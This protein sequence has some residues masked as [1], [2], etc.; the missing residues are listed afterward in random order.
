[1]KVDLTLSHIENHMEN[2]RWPLLIAGP[3]SAES[4]A[5][6]LD[7][8]RQLKETKRISF[9]RAGVWK[10]RTRPG[11]FEGMGEE[12]LK[13]LKVVKEETGLH[14][15]CEVATAEHAELALKYGVDLLWVGARTSANPFSVQD[16]ADSIK[17]T[18][19]AVLVKN[20]VNPDLQLW[21]GALER[22]N[23]AGITSLAAIHRGFSAFE[24]SAFR[25]APMW[26]I[27]IELKAMCPDL[28]V[29]CDPSHIAG[30]RELVP[31]VAQ[32]ALDLDVHGLMVEVHNN[33]CIAKS[34]AAQQLLPKDYA[35]MIYDLQLR[36]IAPVK[37]ELRS[38]L[39]TYRG[40]I[41]QLDDTMIERMAK[42]MEIAKKIGCYKKDNNILVLQLN[43]W[44]QILERRANMGAA[45]GL[46]P[47][48]VKKMM[49]LIHEESIN[50]QT[51]IM[52][53]K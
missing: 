13:W 42:R 46:N 14:T 33:P 26:S 19:V 4:E 38:E 16:I 50:L 9:F 5:Q 37:A 48:F 10:P 2:P 39:D 17:G 27:A 49:T 3:C 32:K 15:A 1:M 18:S 6:M 43:R 52:N 29:I 25:N 35:Q 24:K 22:I 53:G 12:A 11:A 45:M 23:R 36:E 30:V 34:D 41:D 44:E 7:T 8:A 47:E 28:P 20:P 31:L 40:E 21:I 51:E